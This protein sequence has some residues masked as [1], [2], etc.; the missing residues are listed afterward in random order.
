M[1]GHA[2]NAVNVVANW[3]TNQRMSDQRFQHS[4]WMII[5]SRKMTSQ[6]WVSWPMYVR[7]MFLI[8]YILHES[9]DQISNGQSMHEIEL[10]L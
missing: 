5:I 2:E 8:A 4:V 9:V 6:S 7:K 3:R 10:E 1:K